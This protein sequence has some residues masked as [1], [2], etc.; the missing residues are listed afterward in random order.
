M[1]KRGQI[2]LFFIIGIIL[3]IIVGIVLALNFTIW[4]GDLDATAQARQ[5]IPEK[6]RPVAYQLDNCLSKI[7]DDA[8][9]LLSIQGGYIDIPYD[10]IPTTEYTPVGRE[11]YI[12][13]F[14]NLKT[15]VW[16]REKGNGVPETNI[17]AKSYM[18]SELEAYINS[19]FITCL[20]DTENFMQEG[21]YLT[22][23]ATTI[24]T[25]AKIFDGLVKIE[26]AF[27]IT[28]T[29]EDAN[30]LLTKYTATVEFPLGRLYK[31]ALDIIKNEMNAY[32]I[33]NKVIDTLIAYDP[34]IPYANLDTSCSDK[35]WSKNEVRARLM[36]VL[37]RNMGVLKAKGSK[38]E[39][40]DDK[41]KYMELDLLDSGTKDL[42]INFMYSSSWPTMIDI[43]PSE[44]DI[45][46]S[47]SL[48]TGKGGE[49][50]QY[51]TQFMC[52]NEYNFIYDIKFPIMITI[53]DNKDNSFSFATEVVI[54]N[55]QPQV[56]TLEATPIEDTSSLVCKY[57]Q[58]TISVSTYTYDNIG[59]AIPLKNVELLYKCYPSSCPVGI[60]KQSASAIVSTPACYNGAL[61][62]NKEG[63]YQGKE[64]ITTEAGITSY[65]NLF[66]EPL[67][68]KNVVV[69]IIDKFSGE[70]R[71]PYDSEEVLFTFKGVNL[72]HQVYYSYPEETQI[73]LTASEYNIEAKLFRESTWPITT[74]K[75]VTKHCITTPE[76]NIL[77][78]LGL[79]HETICEDIEIP[80][81]EIDQALTG[82][83][84]FNYSFYRAALADETKDLVLY[85]IADAIP[86]SLEDMTKIQTVISNNHEHPSF[87]YPNYE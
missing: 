48:N 65:S 77:G 27:P 43:Q 55:N 64:Y 54:D 69:K 28:V 45:L 29:F 19:Q 84:R 18:E 85:V 58:S 51:L 30:A 67:Y 12:L 37:E 36:D 7:S 72:G 86:S 71:N 87:M 82:G 8:V 49:Y 38:Y 73:E 26:T 53:T 40:Q 22:T 59:A 50:T 21:Y 61:V 33:E 83:E 17:P 35:T 66:L 31:V 76:A 44:G 75:Q 25:K 46:R 62:G 68:K 15:S 24:T 80:S 47:E 79:A 63:Y 6:I 34:E 5:E 39:L 3:V 10:D 9:E 81:M 32:T 4:K 1:E 70:V 2:T 56:N 57:P 42:T 78:I 60:T 13:P 23:T 52:I 41:F 14:T 16:F 20:E 11:L 74:Q